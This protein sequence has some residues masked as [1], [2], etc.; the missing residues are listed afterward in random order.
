MFK[1]YCWWSV[2]PC[3]QPWRL[4]FLLSWLWSLHRVRAWQQLSTV[5]LVGRALNPSKLTVWCICSGSGLS[6]FRFWPAPFLP[7]SEMRR[8]DVESVSVQ[9]AAAQPMW[10][11]PLT[12]RICLTVNSKGRPVDP[13]EEHFDTGA[14]A[15]NLKLVSGRF[16]K[17]DLQDLDC[18]GVRCRVAGRRVL[19]APESKRAA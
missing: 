17:S 15:R 14:L 11:Q 19:R 2:S 12:M 1:K 7:T 3:L 5:G 6:L 4:G 13:A 16:G 8:A 9:A 18:L 10:G